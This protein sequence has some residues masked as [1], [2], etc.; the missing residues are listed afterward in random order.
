MTDQLTL[1]RVANFARFAR[2]LRAFAVRQEA[3]A[4]GRMAHITAGPMA[5]AEWAE[6]ASAA[7][8]VGDKEAARAARAEYAA[9]CASDINVNQAQDRDTGA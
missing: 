2:N 5:A 9:L 3:R 7:Y 4:P 6:K 8:A 1:D